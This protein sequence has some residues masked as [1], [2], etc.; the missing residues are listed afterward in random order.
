MTR[1]E[2][3]RCCQA[4][5]DAGARR[6]WAALA[7]LDLRVRTR[8]EAPD[9]DLDGEEKSALAAA[10]RCALASSRA[11]LDA[12]QN[13]LAGMGRQREGQLAYAQFSEWEQA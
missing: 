8:L 6:D 7:A 9:C 2:V 3:A 12:L 13:R 1:P 10:Y 5:A 4:I 11:E